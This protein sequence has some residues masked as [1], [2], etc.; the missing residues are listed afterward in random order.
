MTTIEANDY[1]GWLKE[2]VRLAE[3]K[4]PGL[5]KLIL[6]NKEKYR[7]LAERLVGPVTS[8]SLSGKS[9]EVRSGHYFPTLNIIIFQ[10]YKE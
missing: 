6:Y 7:L 9:K 5:S 2:R 10:N 4:K 8:S 1:P 3:E